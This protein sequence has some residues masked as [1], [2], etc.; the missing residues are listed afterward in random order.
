M[1]AR[2]SPLAH[3]ERPVYSLPL[4]PKPVPQPAPQDLIPTEEPEVIP[5]DARPPTVPKDVPTSTTDISSLLS[6][7][8]EVQDS[9]TEDLA[10]MAR[11]LKLNTLHFSSSLEKD[12][13]LLETA[14]G[15]LGGNYDVMQ[16]E[17]GRLGAYSKKGGWTTC[18]VIMSV[19]AVAAAWMFMFFVST[20]LLHLRFAHD[21]TASVD[22]LGKASD[23][24]ASSLC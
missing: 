21:V 20:W 12:K 10:S 8:R 22:S 3:I 6:H 7:H 11:Q 19:G 13:E 9:L 23:L 24:A 16:K 14:D 17:R 4:P 1:Q 15:N 2:I 18:Y 5:I